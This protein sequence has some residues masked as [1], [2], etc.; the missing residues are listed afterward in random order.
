[1]KIKKVLVANR[2]EIAI[3]IF[4]ACVEI[5][6][7]TVGIYT[8]ED[9]YS[10]HRYKADEC[11]QIGEDKDPLKPYLDIDAILQVAKDNDVDAIHPG[12][13][14][15][16]ENA[17]F[18][19]KCAENGII[20]VGPK[21]SVLKAL[22]D[23]ITA[24]EVAVANN[25][26]V[27]QSSTADLT[28]IDIA[29]SEANRIKYPIMLKAASGGGGRGMRVI[30]TEVELVIAFPEAKRESLNAFG[31][32]TVFLEKFVENP[33]H[34]EIQIVADEHGN[35][36][37]LY[38]R[39]CSVQRRYQKVIEFAP[40][41][42]L[43]Q[44]TRD[45]LY[46]YALSICKAV[47]YNNIGTVE[48]LVDDDDSIYFI[49]VNPRIQV[50]HT[51]TEMITNIDLVKAQLFIAGGYKL[52]DQQIKIYNQESIVVTGYALQCR[53][54]TEDP[55]ND[56]KP[57]YG[58]VTTYRS[59]SGLG[60]RL[61]AGSIYQ[62]VSI[63]PFFDSMLVKVS[64]ISRTLDGSCR[65]MRRALSE[66]RVR[67]VK[68][69]MAFLDNILK[70]PTFREGKV[71][72]NF[73]K[74]EDKLFEFVEPRNRANKLVQFLGDTIVNGNPD[75]KKIDLDRKFSK[76]VVPAFDK[77]GTYPKGTKDLLTE[78]GPE[79][80]A[81]W[82]KDEKKIHYTDTTMRDAH[83]SLLATRMRTIDMMKVAEGYAKSFPDIFSM[84]VWGGA[85]FDVCLRFLQENPWERLA[86]LRK[87]MPNVLLQMLIRGSNGVGYT[88]YPDN[89]IEKFVEQS[90]ETGVDVFRI[91]DSLNWMK[92]IVP[93]IEHVRNRTEGLAEASICYTG[94]ILN[95]A[96]T[97]YDLKYYI[98]L[99]KDIENAGAHILG[100]KDMA[101]LLKPAAAF[102]LISAFKSEINIP[103]HLHTHD[104]SSI[105]AAMYLKAI[106]AG[107]DVVDVALGGLSGLTSQPNF[108]SVVEMMRFNERESS[109]DTDKLAQYSNYWETVRSYYYTFESG[110]KAG[111][112]EVYI[113]EIPGG[114]YSNLKGQAIALGL[115]DKFPEVTKMY[116][117]VNQLFGDIV[118][119]TPSSKVVGD[120]A[121]YLI[122]NGY[123]T[124]DV[125]EK[126]E[127]MSFPDSVKS[128]FRG[129]LGQPVGGFPKELQKIILRDENPYTERP[130][131]HL[132]PIDFDKEFTSFKRKFKKGMGRDLEITDFLSFMLYPKVFINAYNQHLQYGNVM[133]IPTKNFFYGMDVGEEIIV[134]LDRGKNVLISLM[135]RGEPDE[136]GNVNIFFKVNGQLRNVVVKDTS[137]K[138]TK[139]ENKKVDSTDPKQIG[140]PL[141]GLLS[142]ILVKKGQEIKKNQPLFVIEAM[143]MESTVTATNAGVVDFIQLTG[144]SLV[145]INDLI[146]V[147]K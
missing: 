8:Y 143:K 139:I 145:N 4:R 36:V 116:G 12:Y 33:K 38:E 99:A 26:P 101:G 87:A 115:E 78:L 133:H 44:E 52:S 110:L 136:V 90:W 13:G 108:N 130:N 3:R 49:E 100:V 5:G 98:R 29:I 27:I 24:K 70:H 121:Q 34:I 23:K 56:F 104:T 2:G 91:F 144:G 18:A 71:T 40:S 75:V 97:K 82:L 131:A 141:Q 86:L 20:F 111:S 138:V 9:R 17:K 59:A 122:S 43:S 120:M 103:I 48:F 134:E 109:L 124:T 77:Y 51:V 126:G 92:S 58:I 140:A 137:V 10:L 132:E 81:D 45:S 107:V 83:Q 61:D 62:G 102:E 37:H 15:L 39:D 117:D 35:M 31:D 123:T 57:D 22:G 85:T 94:D 46:N 68:T 30:R 1:M 42:G 79:K 106:E 67:G 129:D 21:V 73:I 93:C 60:I 6:I 96:K 127:T 125:M 14:F 88:A 74:N 95:P 76:P 65:K 72:V 47:D 19:Q 25:V 28:D 54:T 7:K 118:K 119:V 135:L 147:I 11:Y 16:S 69:N 142:N 89:L 128:F 63:S 55:S 50:E 105:Q 113:H 80:F 146:I 32:D 53:V 64:A 84:E 41:I 114:Q 66:F 112:G